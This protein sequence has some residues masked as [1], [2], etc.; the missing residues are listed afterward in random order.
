[1]N[2]YMTRTMAN[3]M[4]A[5]MKKKGISTQQ[6]CKVLNVEYPDFIAAVNGQ[7]PFYNKWQRKIAEAL[8]TEREEL[9]KEFI[10]TP[11]I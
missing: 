5:L 2:H 8:G 11:Q 7:H 10:S 9:L 1:M 3:R 6:I 4:F